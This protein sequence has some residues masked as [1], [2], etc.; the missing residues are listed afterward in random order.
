VNIELLIRQIIK[1]LGQG[2]RLTALAPDDFQGA[3]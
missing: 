1:L 2:D 3:D